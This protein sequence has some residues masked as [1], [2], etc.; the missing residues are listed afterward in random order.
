M[1]CF[2]QI[3]FLLSFNLK[4]I[5]NL[6]LP[7]ITLNRNE[8]CIFILNHIT[9]IVTFF[10]KFYH[11]LDRKKT[12][13][14]AFKNMGCYLSSQLEGHKQFNINIFLTLTYFY[15]LFAGYG[16]GLLKIGP[17]LSEDM[18]TDTK[19]IVIAIANMLAN[20]RSYYTHIIYN[21]FWIYFKIHT[22]WALE[23]YSDINIL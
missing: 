2:N 18:S 22:D 6:K 23:N 4:C 20:K 3:R 5:D 1:Y 15:P 7:V 12:E 9:Y 10:I 11:L 16:F 17:L 8:H 14:F 13:R 21:M 19:E